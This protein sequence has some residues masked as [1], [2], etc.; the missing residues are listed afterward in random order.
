MTR[1]AGRVKGVSKSR[2]SGRVGSFRFEISRVGWGR[3]KR[4]SQSRGSGRVG[5]GQE[6]SKSRGSGRVGS[7]GFQDLAGRVGS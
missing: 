7:R 6:V 3:V 4:Y 2:G 5:S 1:P